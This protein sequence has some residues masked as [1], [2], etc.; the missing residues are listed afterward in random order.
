MNLAGSRWQYT[1]TVTNDV[2]TVAIEE[3]TIFCML[4]LFENLATESVPA[5]WDPL[6][7]QPD[8]FLHDDGFFDALSLLGIGIAA[9]DTLGGY[10]VS[11]DFLGSG[12]SGA[13]PFDIVDPADFTVLASGTTRSSSVPVPSS[14]LLMSAGLAVRNCR[15]RRR[16]IK[17]RLSLEGRSPP[18]AA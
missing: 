17:K 1:Y 18:D 10:A 3:F 4:G 13:Q 6:V 16:M 11:F 14:L 9:G 5:D 7:I 2:L 8:P 15:T 12:S